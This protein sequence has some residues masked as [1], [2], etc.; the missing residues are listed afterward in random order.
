[1]CPPFKTPESLKVLVEFP[2]HNMSVTKVFFMTKNLI[3]GFLSLFLTL[4]SD[5]SFMPVS[6]EP[7]ETTS[8]AL[9]FDLVSDFLILKKWCPKMCCS[10]QS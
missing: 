6:S 4:K 5:S 10:Q 7:V 3:S 1:M 8:V 9:D 2:N